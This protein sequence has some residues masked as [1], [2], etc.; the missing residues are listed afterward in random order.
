MWQRSGQLTE[1]R[2][3][4]LT[5]FQG[6]RFWVQRLPGVQIPR[7]RRICLGLAPPATIYDTFGVAPHGSPPGHTTPSASPSCEMFQIYR[8]NVQTPGLL[9]EGEGLR[10]LLRRPRTF[11]LHASPL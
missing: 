5:P 11:K 8:R 6:V 2:L 1:H 7:A 10:R 9:P 3:L 4:A